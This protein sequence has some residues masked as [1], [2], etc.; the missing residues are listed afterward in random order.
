MSSHRPNLVI[1]SAVIAN[2]IVVLVT[3][4]IQGFIALGWPINDVLD[5]GGHFL[6]LGG[7]SFFKR[8][9]FSTATIATTPD[10]G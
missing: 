8:G 2:C 7:D 10:N 3:L 4:A 9:G 5:F 1:Y 6:S